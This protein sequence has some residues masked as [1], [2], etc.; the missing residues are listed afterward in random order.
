MIVPAAE[1]PRKYRPAFTLVELLVVIAIIGI[2]VALLLPAVQAAR[3]A[4]R[5]SQC[6]SQIRQ[7]GLASLNYEDSKK[8]FPPSLEGAA[9][10]YIA[11]ILPFMEDQSLH[12]LI[13]FSVRWSDPV[14]EGVRNT[15]LPFARCPSQESVQPTKI[16][17]LGLSD[18]Y[19]ID[20]TNLRA[21]YYAVNGAKLDDTRT[22]CRDSEV[23]L[24]VT[25]CG[26]QFTKRG[27]HAVNGIMYPLSKVRQGQITDGT[28]KTFLIAECSWTFT[29]CAGTG[30]ACPAPWYAGS[31][32]WGQ[33]ADTP[34]ELQWYMLK[35]GDGFWAENQSHIV[36]GAEQATS[37][38]GFATLHGLESVR[39]NGVS[40]GSN[41]PGGFHVCQADGSARLVS[42]N[43]D[44]MVLKYF[45]SRHDG[46][47]TNLD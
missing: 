25:S 5:R 34:E 45:A 29:E 46:V 11:T 27:G 8:H 24:E 44:V 1:M 19:T 42:K 6:V 47:P 15:A 33:E 30:E 40:F 12:D 38:S 18:V 14:N 10:S 39:H 2:L 26:V 16:Y 21:H 9:F 22:T 35:T 3:E 13:D 17:E 28:S 41:H 43:T 23:P 31:L 36:W 7:L 32:S 37:D 4:A 20:E